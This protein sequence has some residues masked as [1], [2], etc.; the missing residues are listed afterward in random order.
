MGPRGLLDAA[1][2]VLGRPASLPPGVRPRAAAF[3]GR[4]ALEEGLDRLWAIRAPGLARCPARAQLACLPRYI[5]PGVAEQGAYVWWALSRACHHDP[6]DLAPTVAEI[7]DLL[8][9]VWECLDEI[10]RML[11]ARATRA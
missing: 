8:A 7:R 9:V 10:E 3:L 4:Q 6:Y 1:E 11:G 5:R 2:D